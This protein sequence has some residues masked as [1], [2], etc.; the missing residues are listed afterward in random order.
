MLARRRLFKKS[1]NIPRGGGGGQKRLKLL[2]PPR[3]E[4]H[5]R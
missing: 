2:N 1:V 3:T 4:K 5:E